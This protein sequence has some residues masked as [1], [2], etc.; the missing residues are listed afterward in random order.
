[1]RQIEV[2]VVRLYLNEGEAQLESLL[3]RLHDWE[4][5]KGVSVFRGI[6]GYGDSG[7]IHTSKFIDLGME[8]PLVVEF[9]DTP[10]KVSV[11]MAHIADT[12]KPG[13]M[14]SWSAQINE[15]E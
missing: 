6:A 14:L 4:K 1:M 12:M 8:L 3:K 10:E 15:Y 9:F 13:H 2:T 5:L 7:E 11:I